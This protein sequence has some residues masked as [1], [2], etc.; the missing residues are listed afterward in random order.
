MIFPIQVPYL[1]FLHYDPCPYLPGPNMGPSFLVV[2]WNGFPPPRH[3]VGITIVSLANLVGSLGSI[4]GTRQ[5][6]LSLPLCSFFETCLSFTLF[7]TGNP[8]LILS[9]RL[10]GLNCLYLSAHL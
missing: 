9:V 7:L 6:R 1:I 3:K 4:L 5:P 10:L 2:G 8:W